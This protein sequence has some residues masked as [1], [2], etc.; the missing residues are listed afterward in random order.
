V[1]VISKKALREFWRRH[2]DAER[3]L[4]AWYDRTKA[5]HWETLADTK[6]DFPSADL[7]GNCTIFNIK[8]NAYRLVTKIYYNH[9]KVYIRSVM[10]HK[11]YDRGGWKND[12]ES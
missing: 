12:C 10:T 1:R 3:P 9:K 4:L 5:A 2:R 8:G 6:F 11:D 7:V